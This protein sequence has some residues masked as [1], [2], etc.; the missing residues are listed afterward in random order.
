MMTLIVRIDAD[1]E[2]HYRAKVVTH[3][4]FHGQEFIGTS[5]ENAFIGLRKVLERLDF[6]GK[7]RQEKKN[8]F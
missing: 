4:D 7:L 1:G 2:G 6:F 5:K 3:C 8:V